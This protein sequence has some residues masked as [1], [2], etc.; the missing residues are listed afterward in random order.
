[1]IWYVVKAKMALQEEIKNEK[2]TNMTFLQAWTVEW[3]QIFCYLQS[4]LEVVPKEMCSWTDFFSFKIL[5]QMPSWYLLSSLWF[6]FLMTLNP[7]ITDLLVLYLFLSN[8]LNWLSISLY[9]T[10]FHYGC[11]F[12]YWCINSYY[13]IYLSIFR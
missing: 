12:L 10:F 1:M 8:I 9:M 2:L 5:Q 4:E 13:W 7:W 6:L 3:E 11:P